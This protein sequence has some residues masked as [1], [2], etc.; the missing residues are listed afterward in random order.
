[1]QL[2]PDEQ[3]S[4]IKANN[5]KVL[6]NLYLKNYKKVEQYIID[7]NGSE[8]DARD[9]FQEAFLTTWRNIQTDKFSPQGATSLDGYLYT[10]AKNK[11]LDYLR[12][13]SYKQK[14]KTQ[15]NVHDLQLSEQETESD[16]D[17]EQ[18]IRN[19]RESFRL[20]GENCRNLLTLFYYQKKSI[21]NIAAVF[22][23]TEAT[24]KNNKYRC[25]QK[26]REI[27]NKKNDERQ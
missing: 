9:I 22:G 21:K 11:W 1:M 3:L 23:W 8:E 24:T 10:I 18:A 26:L 27:I 12:S 25:I 19:V 17:Q 7:N 4:A 6:E 13:G 16:N 15:Q 14:V 5:E 2:T 20:L